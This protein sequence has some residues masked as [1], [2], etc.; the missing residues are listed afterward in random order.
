MQRFLR[1]DC[2]FG[3]SND[4]S[5]VSRYALCL[6]F[7]YRIARPEQLGKWHR[8][9]LIVLLDSI[10]ISESDGERVLANT[11]PTGL[12]YIANAGQRWLGS[13]SMGSNTEMQRMQESI[14]RIE[15]KV[16]RNHDA[17]DPR[18]IQSPQERD[19]LR[20]IKSDPN[21]NL[22]YGYLQG[23]WNEAFIAAKV[24]SSGE[25]AQKASFTATALNAGSTILSPLPILPAL[26]S[27]TA[28]AVTTRAQAHRRAELASISQLIRSGDPI[29]FGVFS[30]TVA[31]RFAIAYRDKL[32]KLQN[33]RSFIAK[34]MEVFI[35]LLRGVVAQCDEKTARGLLGGASS[36]ADSIR[37][38]AMNHAYIS[39]RLVK[40]CDEQE[41]EELASLVDQDTGR[42]KD[43]L[44]ERLLQVVD[45]QEETR[46]Q[47]P[48]EPGA[49]K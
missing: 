31:R 46:C 1:D 11:H 12:Q 10:G 34:K 27:A 3:G 21:L 32:D 38:V 33:D 7:H 44:L 30:R 26:L 8:D 39:L 23:Y 41:A 16:D 28:T 47:R 13:L 29:S 49:R 36:A 22:Y 5:T 19:D 37:T 45:L 42:P 6:V 35:G 43:D 40:D 4:I 20:I 14:Q 15:N 48:E 18:M 24:M 25:F 17:I 9:D 2:G